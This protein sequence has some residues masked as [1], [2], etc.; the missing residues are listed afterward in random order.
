[1][2]RPY[3]LPSSYEAEVVGMLSAIAQADGAEPDELTGFWPRV[4]DAYA[5]RLLVIG[6]AV[7]QWID[8]ATVAIRIPRW[9]PR[10]PAA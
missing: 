7:N 9:G 8:K 1:M 3:D 4:G 10:W 2:G 5:G 6:R